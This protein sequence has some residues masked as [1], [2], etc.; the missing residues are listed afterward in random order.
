MAT[1]ARRRRV[2]VVYRYSSDK[3]VDVCLGRGRSRVILVLYDRNPR[4]PYVLAEAER[5]NG[6]IWSYK[7]QEDGGR[8]VGSVS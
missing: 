3:L 7:L 5:A 1:S 4:Q 6:V 8:L 2:S